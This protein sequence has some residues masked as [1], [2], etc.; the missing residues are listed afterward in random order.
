MNIHPY[1]VGMLIATQPISDQSKIEFLNTLLIDFQLRSK[2][3][4]LKHDIQKL[5]NWEKNTGG[6]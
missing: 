3:R 5:V 2:R 1:L 4:R 6:F